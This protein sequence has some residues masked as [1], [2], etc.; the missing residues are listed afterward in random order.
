MPA[1]KAYIFLGFEKKKNS[2]Q[3]K[4]DFILTSYVIQNQQLLQKFP[5]YVLHI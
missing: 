2:L 5:P 4:A 1:I 3:C